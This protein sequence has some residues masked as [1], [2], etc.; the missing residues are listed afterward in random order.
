MLLQKLH[1]QFGHVHN[2]RLRKLLELNQVP[3]R[4]LKKVDEF[5]CNACMQAKRKTAGD[6]PHLATPRATKNGGVWGPSWDNF[7]D[8]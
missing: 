3:E 7:C 8:F 4:I 1:Q 2:A 5:K 6:R